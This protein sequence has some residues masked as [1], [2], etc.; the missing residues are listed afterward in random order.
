MDL[1]EL[2]GVLDR[3]TRLLVASIV[4]L[5]A[6]AALHF[7]VV[8]DLRH[9]LHAERRARCAA[10][11]ALARHH[12]GAGAQHEVDGAGPEAA[13]ERLAALRAEAH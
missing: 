7:V 1:D 9:Q 3:G 12:T 6:L 11:L 8:A 2:E 4:G 10:E 13:C 5:G